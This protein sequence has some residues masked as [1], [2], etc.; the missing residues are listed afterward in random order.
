MTDVERW[1]EWTASMTSVKRLDEGEFELGSRIRIKQPKVMAATWQVTAVN[2][3]RSF[4][5]E[6]KSP[7]LHSRAGHVVEP[8]GDGS[9][10]TL[11]V[12]QTGPLT[13]VFKLLFEGMTRRYVQ[14]E[15]EGLKRRCENGVA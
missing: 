2:P 6:N 9:K 8:E 12:E 5:W 14:T 15:A 1:P 3:G 10:V 7:G 4:E 11:W 13:P